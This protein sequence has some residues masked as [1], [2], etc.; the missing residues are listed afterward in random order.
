MEFHSLLK[1]GNTLTEGAEGVA[2]VIEYV[3]LFLIRFCS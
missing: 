2:Q 3:L 1:Q